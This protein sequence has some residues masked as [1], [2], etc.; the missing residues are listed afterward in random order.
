[1][2]AIGVDVATRA[3][4]AVVEATG[5]CERAL[6]TGIVSPA[7]GA[8]W[9]QIESVVSKWRG[10]DVVALER[11]YL[12]KNVLT[13]EVLARLLGAWEHACASRWLDV[14]LVRASEWQQEVLAGLI[15]R[16]S[17]RTQRK[18]AARIWCRATYG[19]NLDD[20]QSDATA[21][22]TWAVR[23]ERMRGLIRAAG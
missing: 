5:G 16:A 10:V 6:E 7:S 4:W 3:G 21:L 11:P 22:A 23:T 19:L 14:V 15:N 12:D 17:K 13:L 20:D 2:R 9:E 8:V 18:Q 1:V